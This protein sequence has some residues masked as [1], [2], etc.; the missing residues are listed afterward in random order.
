MTLSDVNTST[1]R[2]YVR[3]LRSGRRSPRTIQSYSESIGLLDAHLASPGSRI[4]G[5]G[6]ES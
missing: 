5:E 3:D 6:A 4:H 1:L 2:S